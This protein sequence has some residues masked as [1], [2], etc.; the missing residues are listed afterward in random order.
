MT[1]KEYLKK[2]YQPFFE[3][4]VK[5]ENFSMLKNLSLVIYPAILIFSLIIYTT[6]Y[7]SINSQKNKNAKNL[8]EFLN[9]NEFPS[10]KGSFFK[11]L[12]NP[13]VEF[14]YNIENNDSIGKILKKFKVSDNEIQEI[15]IGLKKKKLTNIYAGRELS[16]VL[17]K[18]ENGNN[19][20]INILYPIN[21][22]LSVEIKKK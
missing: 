6:T 2:N 20:I 9:S 10:V 1:L 19:S 4:N 16:I 8:E 7:N 12:K 22:T 3:R 15:I 13:Y 17:K 5:N 21:N 18:L 11:S 14:V